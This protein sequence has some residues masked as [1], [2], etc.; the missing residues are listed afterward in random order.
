MSNRSVR[1]PGRGA[2][3]L[4]AILIYAQTLLLLAVTLFPV[5]W[6][7]QLSL[8]VESEAFRMPPQLAFWPTFD[9]TSPSCREVRPLLREQPDRKPGDHADLPGAG[10]PG[11]P[12]RSPGP[13]FRRTRVSPSGS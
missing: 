8:K 11:G 5:L 1:R 12:T 2:P 9:T 10:G 13:A 3:S 7:V 4:S 6:L